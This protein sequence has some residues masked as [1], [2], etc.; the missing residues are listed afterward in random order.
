MHGIYY[1]HGNWYTYVYTSIFN[2][3]GVDNLLMTDI[4]NYR[5]YTC[6]WYLLS[7]MYYRFVDFILSFSDN[8]QF[9][10]IIRVKNI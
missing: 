5:K 3:T 2:I 8:F 9:R 10:I 4:G 7:S 6:I 1:V